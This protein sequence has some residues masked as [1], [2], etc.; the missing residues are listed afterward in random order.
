MYYP[1]E[2]T[3]QEIVEL[4]EEMEFVSDMWDNEHPIN[5]ELRAIADNQ[6]ELEY[7]VH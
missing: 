6:R 3:P 1:P 7:V 2:M 4:R 5:C